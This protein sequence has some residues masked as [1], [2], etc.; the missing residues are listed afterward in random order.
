MEAWVRANRSREHLHVSD[1]CRRGIGWGWEGRVGT[2]RESD[3]AVV[4]RR[5]ERDGGRGVGEILV[6]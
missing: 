2:E 3:W 4:G 5:G 1:R 6:T